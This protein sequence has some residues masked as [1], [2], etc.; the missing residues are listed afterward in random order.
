VAGL[1]SYATAPLYALIHEACYGEP[2]VVTRWSSQRVR[3]EVGPAAEPVRERDGV[4]RLPLT[5]ENVSPSSVA[6]DPSVAS[7]FE[8]ADLL[9][10]RRW[11]R[12]LYDPGRLAANT[13]PVVAC[14]YARDMYVDPELSRATAAV[15]RGVT[16][17][18]DDTRHHDALRRHGPEVLDRLEEAL[19]RVAPQAVAPQRPARAE[20]P[21]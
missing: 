18:E 13:V 21:A 15:T 4:E 16:V 17:V 1:I 9:A 8:A 19:A 10:Q 20:V 11:E 12:P 5:G 3:E 14:V 7:L 6:A 2:G